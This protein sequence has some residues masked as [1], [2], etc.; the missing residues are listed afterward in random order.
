VPALTAI[1]A[2]RLDDKDLQDYLTRIGFTGHAGC[3]EA[4][5][6][7]LHA[8]HPQQLPFENLDSWASHPVTLQ[9]A[10]VLHE[11]VHEG[12]GGYCFEHNQ[13]FQRVLETLGFAVQGLSARVLWMLPAQVVLPRT[14]MALLVTLA[15]STWLCDVGFGGMTMT[16]PLALDTH[17]VQKSPH[18]D[19][20]LRSDNGL[21]TVETR[22]KD[23]WQPLYRFSLDPCAAADY[24]TGNWYVSTH[25]DSKFVRHLIVSRPD[26]EGRHALLDRRYTR[27]LPGR[28]SVS[29]ELQHPD[30]LRRLLQQEFRLD[31]PRRQ[32][33]DQRINT[34]FQ[35]N[36]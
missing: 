30:E 9:H 33:L 15:D 36:C 29:Y 16:A 35:E 32:A 22:V 3:D 20:R 18:E 24:E 23:L 6:R 17:G 25:P 8:L 31:L 1:N 26:V 19:Y 4:T 27:H 34:L 2:M 12:R 10:A 11:L 13:L 7:Q 21:H 14:H 28:P 5:L